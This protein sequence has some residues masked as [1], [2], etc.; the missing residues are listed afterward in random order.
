LQKDNL[1]GTN[2]LA[3]FALLT[4]KKVYKIETRSLE[5]NLILIFVFMIP[6]GA[7]VIKLFTAVNFTLAGVSQETNPQILGYK[8]PTT[9]SI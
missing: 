2:T 4:K 7:N 1:P 6:P 5:T 9:E 3:Y 8:R